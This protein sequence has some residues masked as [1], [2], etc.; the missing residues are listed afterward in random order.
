[1]YLGSFNAKPVAPFAEHTSIGRFW[2]KVRKSEGCWEWTGAT[3]YK[4]Y[5]IVW[6]QLGSGAKTR[7]RVTM[8]AHRVSMFLETGSD[9]NQ[10]VLHKCDNKLC[11]RPEHLYVGTNADNMRDASVRQHKRSRKLD[12]AKAA[13]IRRLAAAGC[14]QKE[15][16]ERYGVTPSCIYGVLARKSYMHE[17]Q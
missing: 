15:L 5:G 14:E 7:K 10:L 3:N 13:E 17:E 16:A 1:M 9:A 2:Q 4:G 12:Y 11:V 8:L 6:L